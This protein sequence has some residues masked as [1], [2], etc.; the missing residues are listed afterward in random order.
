MGSLQI[1]VLFTALAGVAGIAL[2]YFIRWAITFGQKGSAELRIQQMMLDAQKEAKK[3][4]TEAE[5]KANQLEEKIKTEAKE[6]EVQLSKTEERLIK[7]EEL[8]DK[9]Q[10]DLKKEEEDV[11]R[12]AEKFA[13]SQEDI[14]KIKKEEE[15]KL[16]KIAGLSKEDAKNILLENIEKN[17]D[18]D[19][20]VRMQKLEMTGEEKLER[21]A[22]EILTSAIH[23]LGN[24][25]ASDVLSTTI[26]I[27]S[28]DIKGKIIGKEGKNIRAFERATGVELIVDD[29]PG[30]IT[31]S[32]FDPIRRHVARV[33]L[34]DLIID[35]RIQPARIEEF[36]E[37]AKEKINKIIKEKGEQAVYECGI[38][39]L[40]P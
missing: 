30:A 3:I 37:K 24:S 27:P 10:S 40:D 35:G 38:S 13:K 16:E 8:L 28:D 39:N 20:A 6:K 36:V 26:S 7:K 4:T 31:I 29:T 14:D 9:R 19:I 25:V 32:S 11:K 15:E 17:N 12:K 2:G 1:L 23:R 18:E 21:R 34:E 22:K 5:N 33:A